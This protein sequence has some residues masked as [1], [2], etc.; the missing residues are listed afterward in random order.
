MEELVMQ[1]ALF[2][3][4]F[5]VF[6]FPTWAS[7]NTAWDIELVDGSTVRAEIV[8]M[9]NGI[10]RLHSDV[11]GEFEVPESQVKVMRAPDAG[12]VRPQPQ[13]PAVTA[14][15][16]M[17]GGGA[18]RSVPSANDLQ[19]ALMRDPAAMSKIQALQNDPLVQ[20]ILN[21]EHTMQAIHAGDLGTLLSDPKIRAL[22]N[23]P[24]VQE[25]SRGHAE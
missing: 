1:A 25:F 20:S 13:T 15:Q 23:H 10:Y 5:L 9:S 14:E 4:F 18:Q 19:Q 17:S 16:S 12:A 6:C 24:T 11:L 22:M 3:V 2:L 8:S 7:G 21:D